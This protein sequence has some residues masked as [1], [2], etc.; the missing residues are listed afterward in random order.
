MQ[1][2]LTVY[3]GTLAISSFFENQRD[4]RSCVDISIEFPCH[5]QIYQSYKFCTLKVAHVASYI[6]VQVNQKQQHQV[7][8]II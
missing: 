7:T 8:F 6:Y 2:V 3:W 4:N 1:Q 5:I